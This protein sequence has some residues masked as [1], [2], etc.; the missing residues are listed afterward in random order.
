MFDWSY[1]SNNITSIYLLI[2]VL[3]ILY[4]ILYNGVLNTKIENLYSQN[5]TT[6]ID[7]TKHKNHT[8]SLIK[9]CQD[10]INNIGNE[11]TQLNTII[12]SNKTAAYNQMNMYET[13]QNKLI[14]DLDMYKNNA[15]DKEKLDMIMESYLN[16][17]KQLRLTLEN[18][19]TNTNKSV[20]SISTIINTPKQIVMP[21]II[22]DIDYSKIIRSEDLQMVLSDIT[23]IPEKTGHVL[24]V[25][26]GG[27]EANCG[28]SG[29]VECV[30]VNFIDPFPVHIKI[31]AGAKYYIEET[32][33]GFRV[34]SIQELSNATPTRLI[35]ADDVLT[36]ANGNNGEIT[37]EMM[38]GHNVYNYKG[39]DGY[40]GGGAA[41]TR[42][43]SAF[44]G[45][46]NGSDGVSYG[47][48]DN[49]YKDAF[50]HTYSGKCIA[51][52][53][54][55][56]KLINKINNIYPEIYPGKATS[57]LYPATSVG[58]DYSLFA[59][60]K[61]LLGIYNSGTPKINIF[62]YKTGLNIYT[63]TTSGIVM[64]GG[65]GGLLVKNFEIV[66]SECSLA[67]RVPRSRTDA[68][69]HKYHYIMQSGTG[70]GAGGC[71]FANGS[72]GCVIINY[73]N[74]K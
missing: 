62:S 40:S 2:I 56:S 37:T 30:I 39:G 33:R 55:H 34:D 10:D 54:S 57:N 53:G 36:A 41:N 43:G 28:R 49:N 31:G 4:D 45:G 12:V 6:S 25:M 32:K 73:I 51:G 35:I 44:T 69:D 8:Q 38:H 48:D 15:I 59:N 58:T 61:D 68:T 18:Y 11:M 74:Y 47:M 52:K 29:Y 60:H 67:C 71:S 9:C 50:R 5:I 64:G 27:G 22:T 14:A 7:I 66:P 20:S 21:K 23:F 65:A 24:F 1:I 46:E 63:S 19:Q 42:S 72:N 26:V 17:I 16:E 13:E 70:Y 3:C